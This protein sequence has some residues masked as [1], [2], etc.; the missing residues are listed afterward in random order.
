MSIQPFPVAYSLK[1]DSLGGNVLGLS[2]TDGPMI[3][4]LVSYN[5]ANK[6]DDEVV[7]TAAQKL[8]SDIDEATKLKGCWSKFKYLNYAASW[9]DP[10]AGYGTEN[11]AFL[12]DVARKYDPEGIFQT[13]CP[14]GFKVF[15]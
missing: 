6:E 15:K 1:T 11:V 5:Y 8:I 10:I 12:Q 13:K 3:L 4:I 2:P 7:T 9:Q 14:G